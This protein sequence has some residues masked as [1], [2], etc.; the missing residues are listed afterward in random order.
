MRFL[1]VLFGIYLLLLSVMPCHDSVEC[2]ETRAERV[3][4]HRNHAS[5]EEQCPPFCTCA[6]CGAQIARFEPAH[7]IPQNREIEVPKS[8]PSFYAFALPNEISRSIW[9]PPKIS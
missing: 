7:A 5:D 4:D 2:N 8:K 1:I 9:Q 3:T 6:C